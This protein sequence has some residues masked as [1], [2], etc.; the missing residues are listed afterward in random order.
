[1]IW[2]DSPYSVNECLGFFSKIY[3]CKM[4]LFWSGILNTK[5]NTYL[6]IAC[7]WRQSVLILQTVILDNT[8]YCSCVIS[9]K[10]NRFYFICPYLYRDLWISLAS[11]PVSVF[12]SCPKKKHWIMCLGDLA[13]INHAFPILINPARVPDCSGVYRN[14]PVAM[15]TGSL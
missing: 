1:M 3:Y 12:Q 4:R 9:T 10:L 7:A 15:Q 2:K 6:F 14:R 11:Q 5:P 8:G 13:G